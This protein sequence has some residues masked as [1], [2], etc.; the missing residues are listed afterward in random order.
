MASGIQ[1]VDYKTGPAQ[2]TPPPDPRPYQR[3][4]GAAQPNPPQ[5][6]AAPIPDP[7]GSRWDGPPPPGQAGKTGF[8]AVDTTRPSNSANPI[9]AP[10]PYRSAP[11]PC[12]ILTG[13]TSGVLT[14]GGESAQNDDAVGFDL[15]NTYKFRISG[16][17]FTGQTQMVQL[18]D[19]WYQAQWHSYDYEMNKIPIIA[20]SGQIPALQ[21]PVMSQ[22]NQWTP[23]TLGQI[24]AENSQYPGGTFYLPDAFG[25]PL[26]VLNG[27]LD[28]KTPV[29]PVMTRPR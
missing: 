6:P 21:V 19:K 18:G 16:T 14:V 17:T 7:S 3:L 25:D 29:V 2:P 11:P 12:S 5:G 1:A 9:P 26:K 28:S 23:V 24:M 10:A 20:G 22:A 27:G 8:W 15:Q 13:A 4:P